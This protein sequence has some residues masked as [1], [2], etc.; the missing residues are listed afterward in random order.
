MNI[1][2]SAGATAV[3]SAAPVSQGAQPNN[4]IVVSKTDSQDVGNN[5]SPSNITQMST[6][7]LLSLH[8]STSTAGESGA[9]KSPSDSGMDF[10][11]LVEMMM[12]M[13]LM[14]MM[15][16]MMQKMGSSSVLGG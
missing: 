7:D 3:Q 11:K 5:Q 8:S 6:Q 14:K 2:A 1:D 9:L 10:S 16:D 15:Q 4:D 13:M 12:V